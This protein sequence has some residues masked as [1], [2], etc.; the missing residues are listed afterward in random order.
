MNFPLPKIL[1][2]KFM[3]IIIFIWNNIYLNIS[4]HIEYKMS[5]ENKIYMKSN[6]LHFIFL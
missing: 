1:K 5:Y 3:K 2:Y 4:L 6:Y